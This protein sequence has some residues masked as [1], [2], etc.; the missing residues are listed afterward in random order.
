[1]AG[2]SESISPEDHVQGSPDAVFTLLEY[3]DYQC[4]HCALTH[5]IIKKLQRYFGDELRFAY[6]HFPLNEIHPMAVPAAQAAEWAGS[7]GKFWEYSDLLYENQDRLSPDLL[8][9]LADKILLNPEE[10]AA[11]IDSG[12]FLDRVQH[13]FEE[14]ERS[15]V[16]GTPTFF[17]N[18]HY[19][20][21][22][23]EFDDMVAAIE[24]HRGHLRR[25]G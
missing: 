15:G 19:Y 7:Y 11:A 2:R 10:L 5:P 3:G 17:I 20:D 24:E 14:G 1:V 25:A 23:Y 13:D 18:G 9:E 22:A 12:R 16:H 8:L 21:G 6:R 4:P